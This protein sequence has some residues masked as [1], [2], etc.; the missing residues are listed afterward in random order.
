MT[1]GIDAKW[2][3]GLNSS[4]RNC[5][6]YPDPHHRALR[7]IDGWI[8]A[9]G[10][11]A[12]RWQVDDYASRTMDILGSNGFRE[13]NPENVWALWKKSADLWDLT[14]L[15]ALKAYPLVRNAWATANAPGNSS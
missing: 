6:Q 9:T 13:T 14:L 7:V 12:S 8:L 2:W 5:H 1:F 15:D 11:A 3:S 4:L 10:P